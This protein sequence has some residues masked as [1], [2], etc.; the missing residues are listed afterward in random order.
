MILLCFLSSSV[1]IYESYVDFQN[2]PVVT[3]IEIQHIKDLSFPTVTVCPPRD[4]HTALNYDLMRAKNLSLSREERESLRAKLYEIFNPVSLHE[5]YISMLESTANLGSN[6]QEIYQGFQSVPR[7]TENEG[8]KVLMW[9]IEGSLETPWFG[10]NVEFNGSEIEELQ[11]VL[12]FPENLV[13]NIGH[14]KLVITIEQESAEHVE[15]EVKYWEGRK[16]ELYTRTKTWKDADSYC[17]DRG[18][19][20]ASIKSEKEQKEISMTSLGDS[21]WVGGSDIEEEGAWK[22]SD[23]GSPLVFTAWRNEFGDNGENSNCMVSTGLT[24]M[25][26][27]CDRHRPFICQNTAH[28]MNE[29]KKTFNYSKAELKFTTFQVWYTTLRVDGKVEKRT[30]VRLSWKLDNPLMKLE[31]R[32]NQLG[33]PLHLPGWGKDFDRK[34]FEGDFDYTAILQFPESLAEQVGNGSLVIELKVDTRQ[35]EGW[36]EEVKYWKGEKY[37]YENGAETWM[38]ADLKCQ[39]EE[40]RLA[41][42]LSEEEQHEVNALG[43]IHH[44]ATWIGATDRENEGDWTWVDGAPWSFTNWGPYY[45]NTEN[46]NCIVMYAMEEGEWDSLRSC[47]YR[48]PYLCKAAQTTLAGNTSLRLQFTRDNLTFSLFQLVYR[49]EKPKDPDLLDSWQDPRMTGFELNW[50][51]ES[52]N[53]S[54]L[55][56]KRPDEVGKWR[57][58]VSI[59]EYQEMWLTKTSQLARQY[60]LQNLSRKEIVQRIVRRKMMATEFVHN[61]DHI[62]MGGQVKTNHFKTLFEEVLSEVDDEAQSVTDEVDLHNGFVIFAAIIYCPENVEELQL[63][64]FVDDLLTSQNPGTIMRAT[65]NTIEANILAEDLRK[66]FNKFFK[67]LDKVLK[68]QYGMILLASSSPSSV[69]K[70]LEK[71]RPY[72]RTLEG[73]IVEQ[74]RDGFCESLLKEMKGD[75]SI[76][77]LLY[78]SLNRSRNGYRSGGVELCVSPLSSEF[79]KRNAVARSSHPFLLLPVGLVQVGEERQRFGLF[80]LRSV[81]ALGAQWRALLLAET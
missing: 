25:D 40:A 35:V 18:G 12:E 62:C 1:L 49:F 20:L 9:N 55:T 60:R 31:V 65:I 4:S 11:M 3:S 66:K 81:Q 8:L 76:V 50:F 56:A 41:S 30:G 51:I 74:C 47:S 23:D 6:L 28:T 75:T 52:Q 22:W 29:T 54:R 24:W 39:E 10:D 15:E 80:R 71:D 16:Y 32:S 5:G 37:R 70:M 72:F 14:G 7:P 42:I 46:R 26:A 19:H 2:S 79:R 73:D 58:K 63:Y 13:D 67:E 38:D 17:K 21:V 77:N 43:G 27:S 45:K 78:V 48:L 68:L 59:P 33:S 53:G 64:K 61:S 34:A 69:Q 57:N 44:W 36:V